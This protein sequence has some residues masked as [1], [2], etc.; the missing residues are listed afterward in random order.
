M[1]SPV[2]FSRVPDGMPVAAAARRQ[3][4]VARL[5]RSPPAGGADLARASPAE[6]TPE[7]DAGPPR[8]AAVAKGRAAAAQRQPVSVTAL[9]SQGAHLLVRTT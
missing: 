5:L 8:A 3:A 9:A 6:E 7:V 4:A 2:N 1:T